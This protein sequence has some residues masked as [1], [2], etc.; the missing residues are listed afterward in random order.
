MNILQNP[1]YAMKI[2]Y[3]YEKDDVILKWKIN[4]M[5]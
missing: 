3:L 5:K 4:L 1:F 2:K